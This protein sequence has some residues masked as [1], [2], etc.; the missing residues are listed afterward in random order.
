MNLRNLFLFTHLI[1]VILWLGVSFTL[2]FVTG[3]AA[4]DPDPSVAAFAYRTAFRLMWTLGGAGIL[5]TLGGGVGLI[6]VMG[7]GFF[8]PF[9]DHWLFQMQLL[10]FAVA[11]VA[12]FYQIPN[13]ER[14]ARAA[15]AWARAGEQPETFRKFRRRNALVGSLI[16]FVLILLTGL[17]AFRVP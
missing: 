3:R 1:G 6:L 11:A 17:G 14:L 7:Y 8:R 10:G 4:K 2:S 15:E 9:P 16:G 5:L 12:L 13:A